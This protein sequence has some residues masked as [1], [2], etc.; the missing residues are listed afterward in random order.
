MCV[1]VQGGQLQGRVG[2]FLS[3]E[4]PSTCGVN[5][6]HACVCV[7][8]ELKW[9]VRGGLGCGVGGCWKVSIKEVGGEA[10]LS[11]SSQVSGKDCGHSPGLSSVLVASPGLSPL[12]VSSL[13]GLE[14]PQIS[15]KTRT[16]QT[17]DEDLQP[18]LPAHV[19]ADAVCRRCGGGRTSLHRQAK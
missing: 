12:T 6:C 11:L 19:A 1:C 15:V 2:V 8:E 16:P 10:P 5:M 17:Q 4:L 9:R 3:F 7:C 18:A 13:S 14:E